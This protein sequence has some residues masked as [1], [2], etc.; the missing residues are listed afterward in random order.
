MFLKKTPDRLLANLPRCWDELLVPRRYR[1]H[2]LGKI[3]FSKKKKDE[4]N[5]WQTF[6]SSQKKPNILMET[7]SQVVV[8]SKSTE[9]STAL[10]TVKH[11][12]VDTLLFFNKKP[13]NLS[14]TFFR[15]S[16]TMI[17]SKQRRIL[18]SVLPQPSISSARSSWS[19]LASATLPYPTLPYPNHILQV[20]E[21]IVR[22]S[23]AFQARREMVTIFLGSTMR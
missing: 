5:N 1:S 21:Q 9:R 4:M 11:K 14:E 22:R 18:R 12:K 23:D 2:L 15:A 3:S 8:A 7:L 19:T 13:H 6:I 16:W 20:L 10:P 17:N